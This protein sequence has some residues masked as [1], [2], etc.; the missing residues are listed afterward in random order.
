MGELPSLHLING[1]QSFDLGS[2]DV[3]PVAVPHDA[4]E[5]CQFVIRSGGNTLGVLTEVSLKVMPNVVTSASLVL[6]GLD[7]ETSVKAMSAALGSPFEATG[8]ARTGDDT[9]IRLEGFADEFSAILSR[10]IDEKNN[11]Q[12]RRAAE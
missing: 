6:K 12:P 8:G 10:Q 4:R 5:P 7:A 9:L 11:A 1:H 3:T 2:L